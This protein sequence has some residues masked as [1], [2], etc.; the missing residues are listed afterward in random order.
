MR[1]PFTDLRLKRPVSITLLVILIIIIAL[2]ISLFLGSCQSKTP[3]TT[4][5]GSTGVTG[6][7]GLV[8]PTSSSTLPQVLNY[9]AKYGVAPFK[10]AFLNNQLVLTFSPTIN[11]LLKQAVMGHVLTVS[12]KSVS[13]PPNVGYASWQLTYTSVLLTLPG[14]FP[15]HSCLI[16]LNTHN[17]GALP[18][19]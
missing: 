17:L 15:Y 8:P 3:S 11:P 14:S 9:Y 10:G 7:P 16:S 19:T 1:V 12:C 18:G 6:T 13:G 4:K 5:H 2:G